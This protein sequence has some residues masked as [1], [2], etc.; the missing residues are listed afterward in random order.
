MNLALTR[1]HSQTSSAASVSLSPTT[2]SPREWRWVVIASLVVIMI[3]TLPYLVGVL[4]QDASQR[5]TGFL[6]TIDDGQTYL[7]KMAQG[8]RG[9][10]L[11]TS[12]YAAQPGQPVFLFP[13]YYLLGKLTGPDWTAR[14]L[15]YHVARVLFGFGYLVAAYAW[16]AKFVPTVRGRR[17][18]F[19]LLA[20]GGGLGWILFAGAGSGRLED[21]PLDLYLPEA[22][23]F[24]SLLTLPH[25]AAARL[26]LVVALLCY[27]RGRV[28]SG[29][30]ALMLV[31]FLV[32][33]Y[34]IVAGLLLVLGE[35]ADGLQTADRVPRKLSSVKDLFGSGICGP[36][37]AVRRLL[38]LLLPSVPYVAYVMTLTAFDPDV[39]R[40]SNQNILRSP[41]LLHYL[42]A[43]GP[44][45]AVGWF[46]W[47]RL[48]RTAP[49]LATWAAVWLALGIAL[50][51]IPITTQRRLIDGYWLWLAP[52]AARGLTMLSRGGRARRLLAPALLAA[53]LPGTL[54]VWGGAMA[55]AWVRAPI[56]FVSR[57]EAV[58]FEWLAA[59][60]LPDGLILASFQTGNRIPA[61]TPYRSVLGH[62][63]ETPDIDATEARV[64]RFFLGDLTQQAGA[65]W[66]RDEG[67]DI[68][69]VG[70]DERALGHF[71]PD[72]WRSLERIY[73]VNG[74]NLYRVRNDDSP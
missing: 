49:A 13:F 59:N 18:G 47:R 22:F 15:G 52:L 42:L 33:L 29:G 20:V 40:F 74:I 8:A 2:V 27:K 58:A 23:S 14:I 5:F 65:Q 7:A 26:G 44:W 63:V 55:A 9:D 25:L 34:P 19:W 37:S 67:V 11:Y 48:R 51:Y 60:P 66:L 35:L 21:L 12:A 3:A 36:R 54:I 24:L 62:G 17:L 73:A 57:E 68:V 38:A 10:W 31:A 45:L 16:V 53:T 28:W 46:G 30:L 70:P 32:P 56:A 50:T 39:A 4:S 61:Y 72:S 71:D 1:S 41:A 43:Y 6:I 69:Y 64:A